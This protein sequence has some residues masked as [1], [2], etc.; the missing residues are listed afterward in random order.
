MIRGCFQVIDQFVFHL[1]LRAHHIRDGV[2]NPEL[3]DWTFFAIG[4]VLI[5]IGTLVLR[6]ADAKSA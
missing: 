3:Y 5:A 2:E 6:S 1:T 4:L